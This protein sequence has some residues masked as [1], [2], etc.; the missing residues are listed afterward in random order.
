MIFGK[1]KNL[2]GLDIGSS[3]IKMVQLR[4]RGKGKGFELVNYGMDK[5]RFGQRPKAALLS[6]SNFGSS[7]QPSAVKMRQ[8]LALIQQQAPWLEIDGE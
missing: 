2:I 1:K 4:E 7:D 3:S 8:A 6:H 5:M